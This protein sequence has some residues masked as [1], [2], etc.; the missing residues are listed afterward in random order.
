MLSGVFGFLGS[1]G[2][3]KTGNYALYLI[4]PLM[5]WKMPSFLNALLT[6]SKFYLS[7]QELKRYGIVFLLVL[8]FTGFLVRFTNNYRDLSNRFQLVAPLSH[9]RVKRI[10][11][12]PA[13]A[14]SLDQLFH[15]VDELTKPEDVILAYHSI[16]LIHYVTQTVPALDSAWPS[17]LKKGELEEKLGKLLKNQ[18][19]PKIVV[20]TKSNMREPQWG[21]IETGSKGFGI[22]EERL[23]SLGYRV[24]WENKDFQILTI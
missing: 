23:I 22:V 10:F 9:E 19:Y 12:S 21:N 1:N 11:T 16:P 17:L 18:Q 5:I 2:G 6:S 4:F 24:I 14:Q 3:V 20:R 8:A 7:Q 13:R 15:K